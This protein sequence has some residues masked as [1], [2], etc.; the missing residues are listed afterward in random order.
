MP[1]VALPRYGKIHSGRNPNPAF[2][3]EGIK[4]L[5]LSCV[6]R[7]DLFLVRYKSASQELP[8]LHDCTLTATIC[9]HLLYQS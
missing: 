2:F 4:R 9:K 6:P 8:F 5:I 7:T 1:Y 3:S